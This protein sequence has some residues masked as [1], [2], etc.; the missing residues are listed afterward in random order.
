M[1]FPGHP[2]QRVA[3]WRARGYRTHGFAPT[4]IANADRPELGAEFAGSLSAMRPDIAQ[5]TARVIFELD[6]RSQ[7]SL[8]Q[9]PVLILQ[10]Q[11][12]IVV[13]EAVGDYLA[14]QIPHNKLVSLNAEGHLPHLS[15]PD[16]VLAA[17]QQFLPET[18]IK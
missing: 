14:S 7:L 8:I 15:A 11:R 3:R 2:A 1:A 10:S 12:D 16:E 6:L 17:I 18:T 9:Q 4:A 5:S 13:P